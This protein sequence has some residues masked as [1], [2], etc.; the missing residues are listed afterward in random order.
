MNEPEAIDLLTQ[1]A[2]EIKQLRRDNELMAARLQ[3]YDQM[4]QL[5]HTEPYRPAQGVSPDVV[6]QIDKFVKAFM[7]K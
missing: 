7:D 5:F 3:M 2:F 6:Y 1:A 4:M